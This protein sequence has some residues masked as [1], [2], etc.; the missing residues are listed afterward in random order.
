MPP[1]A[2]LGLLT[3]LLDLVTGVLGPDKTKALLSLEEAER[4]NAMADALEVIK[5]GQTSK[6]EP[7]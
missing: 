4:A 6:E 2:I 1:A 7:L 5:F 3:G